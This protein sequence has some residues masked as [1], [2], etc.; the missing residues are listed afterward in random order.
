MVSVLLAAC[1]GETYI[2]AQMASILPQMAATD[3]L[4]VSDDSPAGHTATRGIVLGFGDARVRWLQGPG[5]G[6][7]KNVEFLL[8]QARGDIL[9][10]S[11]QDDVW[12]PGKLACV[13][14]RLARHVP[15]LLVHDA[16]IV[17]KTLRETGQTLFAQRK[18]GPG[19][20]RNWRRNGFAGC[21][22]AFTRELLPLVLPFPA[23]IPMHDQWIGLRAAR[24]RAEVYFVREP[25]VL[26]R[27]H[28]GN[29]SGQGSTLSQKLMWRLILLRAY[30]KKVT[31]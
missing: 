23:R 13:R 1:C 31:K 27:R 8:G 14:A 30:R 19:F 11:D 24:R 10:L 16:K 29:L 2:A 25:F 20:W 18:A 26:Y 3:E 5:Q 7:I 4:L 17:D 15:A 21:C 12:L 28:G 6:V 22:M 9:V